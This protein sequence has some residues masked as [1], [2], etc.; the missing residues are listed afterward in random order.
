MRFFEK[1]KNF[2]LKT[3]LYKLKKYIS[4]IHKRHHVMSHI[5]HRIIYAFVGDYNVTF[6]TIIIIILGVRQIALNK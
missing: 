5:R 4:T 1:K 3:I 6:Y 2:V